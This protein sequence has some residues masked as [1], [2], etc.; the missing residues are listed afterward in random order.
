MDDDECTRKAIE[1]LEQGLREKIITSKVGILSEGL[2]AIDDCFS[3]DEK[4]NERINNI[5]IAYLKKY[6]RD[7][8]LH[9]DTMDEEDVCAFLHSIFF[10][11]YQEIEELKKQNQELK[12]IYDEL[13]KC[14]PVKKCV[15]KIVD[16]L[17]SNNN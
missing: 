15:K 17:E 11:K 7:M 9:C 12:F 3:D 8:Q 16:S 13:F 6:L 4:E 14:P 1:L 2:D 10:K 5:K